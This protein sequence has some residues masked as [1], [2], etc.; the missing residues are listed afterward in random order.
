[1]KKKQKLKL[2]TIVVL[3]SFIQ[4]FGQN[5][6]N[7]IIFLNDIYSDYAE[8]A[9]NQISD[10]KDIDNVYEDKIQYTLIN[11]F[12]LKSEY[13]GIVNDYLSAPIQ[14]G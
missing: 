9:L 6:N 8:N 5:S 13:S 10:L 12:F 1:M 4:V 3:I 7:K 11:R 14:N 2:L